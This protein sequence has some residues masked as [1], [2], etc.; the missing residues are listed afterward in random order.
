MP[1][2]LYDDREIKPVKDPQWV[3]PEG[4][5][6]DRIIEGVEIRYAKTQ[7]DERGNLCEIFHPSCSTAVRLSVHDQA[8]DDKGMA[9]TSFARRPDFHKPGAREGRAL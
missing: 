9:H 5:P 3:T 7:S 6:V 4:D 1:S 8:E 2:S